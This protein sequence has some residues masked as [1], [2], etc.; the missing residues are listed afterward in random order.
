MTYLPMVLR[1]DV[2]QCCLGHMWGPL[3]GLLGS[4]VLQI[5]LDVFLLQ[6]SSLYLLLLLLHCLSKVTPFQCIPV[7]VVKGFCSSPVAQQ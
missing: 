5:K 1:A 7:L 2:G 3:V 4:N 6:P